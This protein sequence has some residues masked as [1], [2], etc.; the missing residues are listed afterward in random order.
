MVDDDVTPD[1]LP[2]LG[3]TDW[4]L[5][6]NVLA[7]RFQTKDFRSGLDLVNAIGA[8]AEEAN[9]H[10]DL[11]LRYGHLEVRLM[12]HDVTAVTSRDVELARQISDLAAQ[13][14]IRSDVSAVRQLVLALDT[15]DIEQV[16]PFWRTVLG[17]QQ[18]PHDH[19]EL[20]DPE[21]RL[22]T[23]WFQPTEEHDAPPQRWHLDLWV[24][25]DSV[26][27]RIADALAAGGSLVSEEHVPEFW[28]LADAQ[29]NQVC[30]CTRYGD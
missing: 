13:R 22:P 4:L 19:G 12:S 16:K 30:L 5:L 20:R 15:W 25:E 7:A 9:H 1:N 27:Q 8:A 23:V 6:E 24:S 3:L 10:P 21:G 2:S 26:Q 17:L 28:V 11:D 18:N 29:G 14:G